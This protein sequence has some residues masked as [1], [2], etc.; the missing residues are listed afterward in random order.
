MLMIGSMMGLSA[1]WLHG[2]PFAPALFAGT[3]GGASFRRQSNFSH[4]RLRLR[5]GS[6]INIMIATLGVS[7]VL[8]NASRLLWGSNRC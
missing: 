4:R 5:A 2:M 3:V 7:I 6:L 8:Q 1:Y